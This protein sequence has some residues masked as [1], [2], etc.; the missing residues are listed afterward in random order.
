MTSV[1]RT[2]I[3]WSMP[4]K[5]VLPTAPTSLN[6]YAPIALRRQTGQP[7]GGDERRQPSWNTHLTLC[8][9]NGASEEQLPRQPAPRTLRFKTI[10]SERP[11]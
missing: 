6:H 4:N 3:G 11:S 8:G 2:T 9:S 5:P 7:F 1:L 10:S